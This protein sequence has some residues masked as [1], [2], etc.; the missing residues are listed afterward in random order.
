VT[1]LWYYSVDASTVLEI[2]NRVRLPTNDEGEAIGVGSHADAGSGWEGDIYIDDPTGSLT[3]ILQ[4]R[5]IYCV[6][7]AAPAGAQVVGNWFVSNVKVVRMDPFSGAARRWIVTMADE[8]SLLNRRKF[9]GT[10]ANRAAE[11]D[12]VRLRW[13]LTTTEGNLFST[14]ET[15]IDT[16]NPVTMDAVDLRQTGAEEMFMAMFQRSKKHY[17]IK[18]T[19]AS[20]VGGA[21]VSSSVANPTIITTTSAHG[22][23]TGMI[24][25][26]AGH[27]GS[28]PSI[29]GTHTVTVI[30][31]TTFSIPVNV[32]VGGTGGTTT[33]NGR[34][35]ICYFNMNTS[36]LYASTVS[37]S[38][39]PADNIIG[40]ANPTSLVYPLSG[41]AELDRS[42]GR[43]G[44]GMLVS[45][46]G[47]GKFAYA[48]DTSVGDTYAYVDRVSPAPQLNTDASALAQAQA[49][50]AEVAI[51]DDEVRT[52]LRVEAARLNLVM[53]GMKVPV[54]ATHFPNYTAASALPGWATGFVDCRVMER[55]V[56]QVGPTTFDVPLRLSPMTVPAEPQMFTDTQLGSC[57]AGTWPNGA[58]G[59]GLTLIGFLAQR[60]GS[61]H[62]ATIVPISTTA[63]ASNCASTWDVAGT[64]WTYITSSD[65]RSGGG[66][67]PI[68]MAKR[69]STASDAAF[70]RWGGT[71]GGLNGTARPRSH[72][73][74]VS[75]LAGTNTAAVVSVAQT[76][77]GSSFVTGSFVVTTAPGWIYACLSYTKGG[78][79]DNPDPDFN[80]VAVA[81]AEHLTYGLAYGSFGPRSAMA[82][83]R[84]TTNGT[85][86]ISWAPTGT[87]VNPTFQA[88]G[89][90]GAFFPDA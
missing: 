8:N 4:F 84:V 36:S 48:Q 2:T 46:M 74:A 57:E 17:W 37:I 33:A 16:T 70:L 77:S 24:V 38:N 29:N 81:P 69:T 49:S 85:Y 83:L 66:G 19:E 11:T 3:E 1:L 61:T 5:R 71:G 14:D 63:L 43:M 34:Y 26:I 53:H 58:P 18:Y 68:T 28:T 50:L 10:D 59:A 9:V 73:I 45:H 78:P 80:L 39:N 32:T 60:G 30:S 75:G 20:A 52:T 89:S 79:A 12:I 62:D 67:Y 54:K 82:R 88:Y 6:Q 56:N 22:L 64:G 7:D 13:Y 42:G 86:T 27:S 25:T 44:S 40:A 55:T 76:T 31:T 72:Q 51:P 65:V 90:I 41:D 47:P 21:I 35:V 15:F 87:I 23:Y